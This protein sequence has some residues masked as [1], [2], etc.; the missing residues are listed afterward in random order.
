MTKEEFY[1]KLKANVEVWVETQRTKAVGMFSYRY[2]GRTYTMLINHV[3]N[4]SADGIAQ[5]I[6]RRIWDDY[7]NIELIEV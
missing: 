1:S 7:D 6:L 5:E 3:Y 4:R 2:K